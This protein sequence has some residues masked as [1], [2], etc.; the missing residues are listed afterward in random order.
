M[1]KDLA[2][3]ARDAKLLPPYGDKRGL[4]QWLADHAALPA[5]A[6]KSER[7]RRIASLALKRFILTR[8]SEQQFCLAMRD[9]VLTAEMLY[10]LTIYSPS[11]KK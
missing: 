10:T 1:S 8:P 2:Q 7:N 9:I 11:G 3:A 6:Q 4:M 5:E